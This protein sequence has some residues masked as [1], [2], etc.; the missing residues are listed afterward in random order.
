MINDGSRDTNAVLRDGDPGGAAMLARS[1]RSR[2]QRRRQWMNKR[3]NDKQKQRKRGQGSLARRRQAWRWER[4]GS[5]ATAGIAAKQAAI[6]AI[7]ALSETR[8]QRQE[9]A[10]KQKRF[11]K[12]EEWDT[13][14]RQMH[15]VVD[16]EW[17]TEGRFFNHAKQWNTKERRALEQEAWQRAEGE[18][19]QRTVGRLEQQIQNLQKQIED[20]QAR[21]TYELGTVKEGEGTVQQGSATNTTQVAQDRGHYSQEGDGVN[22]PTWAVMAKDTESM[23][24]SAAI[25]Q[26]EVQGRFPKLHGTHVPRALH[27]AMAGHP[28]QQQELCAGIFRYDYTDNRA[29][30]FEAQGKSW[31]DQKQAWLRR[32]MR[33]LVVRDSGEV[34]A[35]GLHKF[36]NLGQLRETSMWALERLRIVEVTTKLDGQM[37]TGV[38]IGDDVVYWSRK[39]LTSVGTTAHRVAQS[40]YAQYDAMVKRVQ[41]QGAT[42][43]FEMIGSQSRIKSDEGVEPSLVLIAVRENMSGQ[44]WSHEQLLQLRSEFKVPVVERMQWLEGM[45]IQDVAR[46]VRTWK[47]KEGVI[48]KMSDGSMVKVKSNWWF[49]AGYCKRHRAE[50]QQWKRGE[51]HRLLRQKERMHTRNQRLAI[52]QAHKY[53]PTDIF[54]SLHK[55]QKLEAVYNCRGKLTVVIASFEAAKDMQEGLDIA[56]KQ[57]WTPMH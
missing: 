53:K 56:K 49:S 42:A 45:H 3:R 11:G 51:E 29:H 4:L 31:A 34:V 24:T 10:M 41:T 9:A 38:V 48:V 43:I 33:G 18:W 55:A 26:V 17:R 16:N 22:T 14:L 7:G 37:I 57:N 2:W 50:T 52:M 21:H 39:G 12:Q 47:G 30:N 25:R 27:G 44:Y 35:R 46:E 8:R 6:G 15:D 36:F 19:Q 5:I 28:F 32:E 23:R 40:A 13:L 20:M 1:W 54:N